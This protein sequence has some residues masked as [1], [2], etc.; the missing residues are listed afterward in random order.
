MK[1]L[2]IATISI[3]L[4]FSNNVQAD[5]ESG[6]ELHEESCVRCH[7]SAVYTRSNA[8]IKSL[9]GLAKQV[10]FCKNNLGISWFDEDVDAVVDYLNTQYYKF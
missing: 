5:P 3:F 9:P 6:A 1:A 2:N 10:R 7:S 4:A 8:K